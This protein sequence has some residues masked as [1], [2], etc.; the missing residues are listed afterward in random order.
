MTETE[1]NEITPGTPEFD[2]MVFKLTKDVNESTIPSLNYNG[3]QL[4]ELQD[5]M[6]VM[7]AYIG[8]E[9]NLF[10]IVSQLVEDDW[11]MAFAN[12]TIENENEV[13]DLSEPMTTGKGLNLLGQQ[14]PD[15][16]NKL[17]KYFNTLVDVNRGEWRLV[18]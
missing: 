9:F 11:I 4:Q 17:L 18:E 15:D 16:A 5:G 6:F 3:N 2:Q 14:S 10:F 13:T 12:A 1:N 8:E 7:P